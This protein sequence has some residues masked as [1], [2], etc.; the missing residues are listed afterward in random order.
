MEQ[1]NEISTAPIVPKLDLPVEPSLPPPPPPQISPREHTLSVIAE[2]KRQK[3][4]RERGKYFLIVIL[5][6]TLIF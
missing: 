2:K 5:L 6:I 3:W 1:R 4:L